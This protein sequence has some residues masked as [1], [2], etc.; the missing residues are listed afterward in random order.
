MSMKGSGNVYMV[1]GLHIPYT[2]T[3]LPTTQ[4]MD[5]LLCMRGTL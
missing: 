4:A 1:H 5:A 2:H 3:D